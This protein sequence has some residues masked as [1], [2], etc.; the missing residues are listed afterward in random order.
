MGSR[1]FLD[2]LSDADVSFIRNLVLCSGSLKQL[3]KLYGVSYPTI[4][5]RLDRVIAKIEVV[6]TIEDPFIA[7]L[8]AF[9]IEKN[10][11]AELVDQVV[12]M[13]QHTERKEQ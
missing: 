2:Y 12:D 10:V 7:K 3:T 5:L 1:R 6:E 9:A 13:Y 11:P 4:R 8:R